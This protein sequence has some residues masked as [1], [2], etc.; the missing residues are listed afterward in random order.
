M[1]TRGKAVNTNT[2]AFRQAVAEAVAQAT[3]L[4]AAQVLQQQQQPIPQNNNND[5]EPE[6]LEVDNNNGDNTVEE[7]VA[8]HIQDLRQRG[9]QR[10]ERANSEISFNYNANKN[11][12]NLNNNNM[13][14]SF[15]PIAQ[16]SQSHSND[17]FMPTFLE[18]IDMGTDLDQDVPPKLR[19]EIIMHKFVDFDSLYKPKL[20]GTKGGRHVQVKL[21]EQG[22]SVTEE[23]RET[24]KSSSLDVWLYQFSI[25]ATVMIRSQPQHAVGLFHYLDHI[26]KLAKKGCDWAQYDKQFRKAHA[27][28]PR[29][30]PFRRNMLSIELECSKLEKEPQ[31]NKFKKQDRR[32]ASATYTGRGARSNY[33]PGGK[34]FPEGTCWKWN[35]GDFC[36]GCSYPDGHVCCWCKGVHR[37]VNCPQSHVQDYEQQNQTDKG[38]KRPVEQDDK[39]NS[40]QKKQKP[41]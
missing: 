21:Q 11:Y 4:I 15:F 25:Y 13:N 29:K 26:R 35:R 20:D 23:P 7:S 6:V 24:P 33:F 38:V 12:N 14:S 41:N 40:A 5:V 22:F 2:K 9:E 1:S 39:Q 17:P 8:Q 19:Q 36:S 3:P 31:E 10:P 30:Y 16:S 37:A 27:A 28:N 32:N 34:K 18:D